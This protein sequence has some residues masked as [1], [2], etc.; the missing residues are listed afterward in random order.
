M[1]GDARL[2]EI[3]DDEAGD[4]AAGKRQ[5]RPYVELFDRQ[6]HEQRAQ[7]WAD[8]RAQ[9][10]ERTQARQAKPD[11]PPEVIR[12]WCAG[13]DADPVICH[14]SRRYAAQAQSL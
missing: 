13:S 3:I 5:S 6:A 4:G 1:R 2:V 10:A 12:E 11:A 8:E 14:E 7:E 9:R